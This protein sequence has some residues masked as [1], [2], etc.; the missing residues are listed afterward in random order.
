MLHMNLRQKMI[1]CFFLYL[2]FYVI[3]GRVFHRDFIIFNEDVSLMMHAGNLSNICLEIR[4]YEKNYLINHNEE[5]YKQVEAYIGEAQEYLPKVKKELKVITHPLHLDDL[6]KMLENY[7]S[8]FDL[9][10]KKCEG[11][12]EIDNC[13]VLAELRAYGQQLVDISEQLVAYEQKKMTEFIN[14]FRGQL[15]FSVSILILL[16]VFT[17]FLLYGSIILP[18]KTIEKAAKD[19]GSGSFE[20]L[21]FANKDDEVSSVL[22]A[23]NDMIVKLEDNQEQL[24]QAKKLSSIGTLASGT[25]HQINNPLNNIATSCQLALSEIDQDASPFIARMLH[26]IDSESQRAGEIVRGLLEFS[27]AHTFSLQ[28]IPLCRVVDKTMRLVASEVPAGV[29]VEE[30]VDPEIFILADTQKMVEAFLNLVINGIHAIK[31]PPGW[32]RIYARKEEGKAVVVVSDTGC[33]IDEANIQKIFDPFFTTK[34]EG[35][36]TGLGLAVVFGIIKKHGG[37]IRV[38]SEVNVGTAFTLTLPLGREHETSLELSSE[39]RHISM[40]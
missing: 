36:G 11:Y 23:M 33:G 7:K 29:V 35:S 10:K 9:I 2:L 19:I 16:S 1:F 5:D 38:E 14:E 32:V 25:A 6:Q 31:E 40:S 37:K 3:F 26:T 8:K 30:D 21:H 28:E 27:R 20:Q 22:Q 4:R 39:E 18:L 13:K 17:L 24:F 34:K 12:R 15:Y